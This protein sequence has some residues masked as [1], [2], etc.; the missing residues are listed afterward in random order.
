MFFYINFIS[1][2]LLS[3]NKYF[4]WLI[5][6]YLAIV[7]G[8]N[9]NVEDFF[10][11]L[12]IYNEIPKFD[13][14]INNLNILHEIYGENG[15]LIYNSF[16]K[17]IID[18]YYFLRISILLLSLFIIGYVFKRTSYFIP[19]TLGY[20]LVEFYHFQTIV[21]RTTIS[22]ALIL[23]SFYFIVKRSYFFSLFLFIIACTFHIVAFYALFIYL[24]YFLL[25]FRK[26]YF[27]FFLLITIFIAK[28]GLVHIL[29][30]IANELIPTNFITHK[31]NAM[32]DGSIVY[33]SS[34][35]RGTNLLNLLILSLFLF[36]F[37]LYKKLKYF[38]IFF[39]SY[40]MSIVALLIFNDMSIV[41][42]R[43]FAVFSITLPIL[44]SYL[45]YTINKNDFQVF[46]LIVSVIYV[47][48][49][50]LKGS[51]MIEYIFMGISI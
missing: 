25:P 9:S 39:I 42:D 16:I 48:L 3:Y 22:T 41:G 35:L 24:L 21:L 28:I 5:I 43:I 15:Y 49:F 19:L 12:E 6:F 13:I 32:R 27:L 34:L 31:L 7:G 29:T 20:Y 17:M 11:Y 2:Y 23:L 30:V 38:K 46:L 26:I 10:S 14:L 8:L 45:L 47:I 1:L 33:S 37:N 50:L 44:I 51:N 4:Y 40:F 36:N 18:N